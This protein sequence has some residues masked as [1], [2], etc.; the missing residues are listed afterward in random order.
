MIPI[1]TES[2]ESWEESEYYESGMKRRDIVTDLMTELSWLP[3]G[4]VRAFLDYWMAGADADDAWHQVQADERYD[5]WFPENRRRDG[6]I[7]MPEYEYYA[8][9]Q[10]YVNA[11]QSVGV[12]RVRPFL[13]DLPKLIK[14][15]VTVTE[16]QNRLSEVTRRVLNVLPAIQR[17]FASISNLDGWSREDILAAMI[18]PS[19]GAEMLDKQITLAEIGGEAITAGWTITDR[20]QRQLYQAGVDR[21]VAHDLFGDAS[22]LVP[23]LS[24]LARRHDDPDDEFDLKDFVSSAV[25]NDPEQRRRL[26]RL[27]NQE[28]TSFV[29]GDTFSFER[30]DE[31]GALRGLQ[32][33]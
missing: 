19:L 23:V 17:E 28:R 2:S 1:R 4:A 24:A 15:E 27:M 9:M 3:R 18:K 10:G 22:E 32:E 26:F 8:N 11:L 30:T 29:T 16:F 20:M 21:D 5:D 25:Y 14:G 33:R 13:D 7:R 12:N 6:T 31:Q